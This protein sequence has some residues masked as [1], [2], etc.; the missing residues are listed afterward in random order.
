MST[1]K[2]TNIQN[3]S[4][5]TTN[6]AL[7]TNG[8]ATVAGTLAMS[9]PFC[10]RNFVINGDFK[11]WQRG[12]TYALTTGI[13][14]GSADR[15]AFVMGGTAAGIANQVAS[16]LT[17][18]Q[19]AVKLGRNSAST[20]TGGIEML[21]ALETVNSLPLAGKSVT[22]SF[23][24]KA[25]ANLSAAGLYAVVA[26]GTGTD[27]SVTSLQGV[28][29][30]YTSAISSTQALT[31]SWVRY[32]FT[33][34]IGSTATQVGI[35]IGYNPTGTAGADDNIYVTGVQLE[36]GS[37]ATPFEVRSYGQELTL[38]QRYYEKLSSSGSF[39]ALG[40]AGVFASTAIFRSYVN[41]YPKRVAPSFSSSAG[42]TFVASAA[43]SNFAG[44]AISLGAANISASWVSLT[45]TGATAGQ[46]GYL[47][48]NNT[49]AF[50][51][52]DAEL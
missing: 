32:S 10:L 38:A 36:L 46:A 1:L 24:A 25:G 35:R 6:I 11:I 51:A 23:W 17:G 33:G 52:F 14:Y 39:N 47:A 4:S 26:S 20:S 27:Q 16:G 29:T 19:Y 7:D 31:T 41:Y 37:I 44:S 22:L 50:L 45:V 48:D 34:T 40:G 3:A 43:G 18:F 13:A 9:S 21:Q 28:W 5:A 15:F 2:A 30:G 12:T 42:S 8:N 49:S